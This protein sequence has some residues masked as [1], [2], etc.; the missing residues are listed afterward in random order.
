MITEIDSSTAKT[1]VISMTLI[2]LAMLFG[3]GFE[4][5][6][7]WIDKLMLVMLFGALVWINVVLFSIASKVTKN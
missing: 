5:I 7:S 1:Q 4:H 6:K 3:L 2:I